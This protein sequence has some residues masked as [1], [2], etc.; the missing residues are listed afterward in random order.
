M[1]II[2]LVFFSDLIQ[3]MANS[4][5]EAELKHV[6]NEWRG[7]TG[8]PIRPLFAQYVSLLN[9]AATLNSNTMFKLKIYLHILLRYLYNFFKFEQKI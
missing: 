2:D 4:R 7:K 6:W 3:I 5:N 9:E 1:F 8:K